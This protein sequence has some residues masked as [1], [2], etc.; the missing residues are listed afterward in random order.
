[1]AARD[2][3]RNPDAIDYFVTFRAANAAKVDG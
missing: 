2:A 1:V 3:M